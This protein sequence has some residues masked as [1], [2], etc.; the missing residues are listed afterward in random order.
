MNHFLVTIVTKQIIQAL[1]FVRFGEGKFRSPDED[2]H[3]G[4]GA[5]VYDDDDNDGDDFQERFGQ[6]RR[7]GS[8]FGD[9]FAQVGN[10]CS[11][12]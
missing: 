1:S 4:R 11:V 6:R 8:P 9:N 12:G 10:A 5:G 2:F 7:P 3:E